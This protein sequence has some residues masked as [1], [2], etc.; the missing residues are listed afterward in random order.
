MYLLYSYLSHNG[1]IFVEQFYL[2]AKHV[3]LRYCQNFDSH[4]HTL[5]R[6]L[7]LATFNEHCSS[8]THSNPKSVAVNSKV[9]N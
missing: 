9:L 4:S 7:L 6:H 2:R 8:T 5:L 1:I 3:C